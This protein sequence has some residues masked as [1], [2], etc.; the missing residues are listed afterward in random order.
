MAVITQRRTRRRRR[1]TGRRVGTFLIIALVILGVALGFQVFGTQKAE[2]GEAKPG[3]TGAGSIKNVKNITMPAWVTADL[4]PVNE[5][6]RP[7]TKL[8]AV[9]AIVIHYVGNP[10]TTAEQNRSYYE[11]LAETGETS[12]SSNFV[13]GTDGGILQCVPTDEV[14]YCSNWRNDDT[15]SI[16]CC[17]PDKTGKFT[18]DTYASL[19][20]LTAYLCQAYGLDSSDVIRHYDV[21]GK[22]CPKYFVDHPD[23]W[24]AFKNDVQD[25]LEALPENEPGQP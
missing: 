21:T 18:D 7:G 14:A 16:E 24:E 17:H 10:G 19:V 12:A 11:N 22:V 8:A 5:Y 20:K 23:A 25:A 15:I 4:L 2:A 1:L 13:I 3:A 6:S 9:N